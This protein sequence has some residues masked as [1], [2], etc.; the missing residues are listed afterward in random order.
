MIR[1]CATV[2]KTFLPSGRKIYNY[3]KSILATPAKY[4]TVQK[5]IYQPP[6]RKLWF[7]FSLK[8]LLYVLYLVSFHDPR[9]LSPPPPKALFTFELIYNCN[10]TQVM[11]L[12]SKASFHFCHF[13]CCKM[14]NTLGWSLELFVKFQMI[15]NFL[16]LSP[17]T[18]NSYFYNLPT[19]PKCSD[20]PLT[21]S[22]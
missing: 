4:K 18:Q 20:G 13:W 8:F 3:L 17:P 21:L 7:Y 12:F 6:N 9:F 22:P 1:F 19:H 5:L 14:Y 11:Q 16:D 2:R 10:H 15:F